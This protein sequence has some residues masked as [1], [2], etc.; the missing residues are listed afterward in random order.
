MTAKRSMPIDP[1]VKKQLDAVVGESYEPPR[2]WGA[3]IAKWLAF[4]ALAI[5]AAALVVGILH[6]HVMKAQTA[7]APP[8]KPG[9][10]WIAPTR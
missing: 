8:K 2:R 7:P 9:P 4:A 10:V 5:A 3:T 6:T 1:E